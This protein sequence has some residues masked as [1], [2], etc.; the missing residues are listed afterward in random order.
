MHA[1]AIYYSLARC[2]IRS[3]G[4][5]RKGPFF[6]KEIVFVVHFHAFAPRGHW[7]K[8]RLLFEEPAARTLSSYKKSDQFCDITFQAHAN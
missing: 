1:H 4:I 7:R 5:L 3:E 8:F 2:G 6:A